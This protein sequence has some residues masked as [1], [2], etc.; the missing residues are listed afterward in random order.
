[1]AAWRGGR[2]VA[3]GNASSAWRQQHCSG[4][5]T[6]DAA[7]AIDANR[8]SSVSSVAGV[9]NRGGGAQRRISGGVS[10]GMAIVALVIAGSN[11]AR[12]ANIVA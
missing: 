6:G 4:G 10:A 5:V 1:M 9:R 11:L 3:S 12:I 7:S 8:S 2:S